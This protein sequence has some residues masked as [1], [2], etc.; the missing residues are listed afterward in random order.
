MWL[1]TKL[2]K[3][4]TNGRVHASAIA[5]VIGLILAWFG[6]KMTGGEKGLTD[7]AL[8][9]GVGLMGGAMLRDFTIVAT[10]FEVQATEAKKAGFIGAFS[11]FF[12]G[13]FCHLLSVVCLRGF[14]AIA[15]R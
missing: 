7:L 15:M 14:L 5:I 3:Y 13:P 11:F 10:A 4:L 1:S 9:T 12:S 2:S 6:G 8:F